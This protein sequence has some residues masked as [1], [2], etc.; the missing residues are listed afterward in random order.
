MFRFLQAQLGI[1]FASL[2]LI[3]LVFAITIFLAS[4]ALQLVILVVASIWVIGSYLFLRHR[5]S[6]SLVQQQAVATPDSDQF[7]IRLAKRTHDLTSAFE[8]SQEIIAQIDLPDLLQS[9]T[10]RRTSGTCTGS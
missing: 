9:T 4:P 1:I 5:I 3:V 2:L 7:E 6:E 10:R 8:L